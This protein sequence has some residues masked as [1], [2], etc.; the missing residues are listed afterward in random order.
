[1]R[2]AHIR[3]GSM[4]EIIKNLIIKEKL[5]KLVPAVLNYFKQTNPNAGVIDF[6]RMCGEVIN[7]MIS[8]GVIPSSN[9]DA[10][11]TYTTVLIGVAFKN[12]LPPYV[13]SVVRDHMRSIYS[14]SS[15]A[16]VIYS[17]C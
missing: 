4:D 12:G 11:V 14:Y 2:P 1:M 10:C 15:A 16:K 5:E 13:M 8:I 3:V 17:N 6:A 9:K 7:Y